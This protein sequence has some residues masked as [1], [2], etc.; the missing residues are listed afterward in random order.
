MIQHTYVGCDVSKAH[1]DLYDASSGRHER[2]ANAPEVIVAHL[3]AYRDRPVRFVFEATG[4][5]GNVLREQLA[6]AGLAGCQV[7]PMRARR[8]AQSMG[9]LAKPALGP[10]PGGPTGSTRRCWL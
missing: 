10:R 8:C 5:Y 4:C 1:V 7:N 6:L 9:R 3:A 2:I